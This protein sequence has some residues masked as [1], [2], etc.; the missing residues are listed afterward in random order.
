MWCSIPLFLGFPTGFFFR[1]AF[2]LALFPFFL[3]A[4][5]LFLAG[6]AFFFAALFA[7]WALFFAFFLFF[8]PLNR[9]TSRT[10]MAP[11]FASVRPYTVPY[12]LYCIWPYRSE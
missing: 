5:A 10:Y 8:I 9:S 1:A 7:G 6:L 12:P 11:L 2:F 3:P 4:S